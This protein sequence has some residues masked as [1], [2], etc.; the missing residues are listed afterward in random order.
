MRK[1]KNI[2]KD[3]SKTDKKQQ[4]LNAYNKYQESMTAYQASGGGEKPSIRK[5]ALKFAVSFSALQRR[6]SGAV[7]PDASAG[8]PP[9]FTKEEEEQLKRWVFEMSDHG[10]AVSRIRTVQVA[11]R[12]MDAKCRKEK[13][14]RVHLTHQ[15]WEG[16][17]KRHP[18][19]TRRRTA[20]LQRARG[21]ALIY[22]RI[23]HFFNAYNDVVAG[24]NITSD[25]IYN[26]DEVGVIIDAPPRETFAKKG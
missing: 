3:Q 2:S 24:K 23:Q 4:L 13:R 8:R 12:I 21:D 18:D 15:W 19:I 9:H 10:F 7:K 25:R 1:R 11:Q 26:C 22:R 20:E 6:V 5:I 17:K 14:R 16:F